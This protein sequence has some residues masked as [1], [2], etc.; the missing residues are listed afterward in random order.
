MMCRHTTCASL[1]FLCVVFSTPC[2]AERCFP[3][4]ILG[5]S[6]PFYLEKDESRIVGFIPKGDEKGLLVC[7]FEGQWA[8]VKL[9]YTY[10]WMKAK[11][12]WLDREA[13]QVVSMA[14][15]VNKALPET[16]LCF[17]GIVTVPN[18]TLYQ[19]KPSQI[20]TTTQIS[21]GTLLLA[22]KEI[23]GMWE[24]QIEHMTGFIDKNQVMVSNAQR[25]RDVGFAKRQI[26]KAFMWEGKVVNETPLLRWEGDKVVVVFTISSDSYV[27][28]SETEGDWY[29]VN[30]GGQWGYVRRSDVILSKA[31]VV[32]ESRTSPV[33]QCSENYR[34]ARMEDRDIDI[35]AS[36]WGS[37]ILA[38][39]PKGTDFI[40]VSP[41][42]NLRPTDDVSLSVQYLGKRGWISSR[43]IRFVSKTEPMYTTFT[44]EPADQ[45][46]FILGHTVKDKPSGQWG[47]R[48]GIA[49]VFSSLLEYPGLS[50]DVA[51]GFK[52]IDNLRILGGF[53]G[54]S[55]ISLLVAGT[56][57]GLDAQLLPKGSQRMILNMGAS[58][59]CHWMGGIGWGGEGRALL[60]GWGVYA[61]IGAE[62]SNMIEAGLGYNLRGEHEI[63]CSEKP[64]P[65]SSYT[66]FHS[67]GPMLFIKM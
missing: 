50:A 35:L 1:S 49:P 17:E 54:I 61:S 25:Q 62:I 39:I 29:W 44:P 59:G 47:V 51:V 22:C 15:P 55:S 66:L 65:I 7:R 41:P 48:I 18:A 67:F 30:H 58:I 23:E 37:T 4:N 60:F 26:C 21:Q 10:Y 63:N 43:G 64:C 36:P 46:L 13:F 2:F 14:L 20:T 16:E 56:G 3:A 19:G 12:L 52:I 53:W 28:V 45:S 42:D 38:V 32:T 33:V 57:V 11:D 34:I 40:V 5:R 8:R 6:A 9:D 24:V 27:S 31:V